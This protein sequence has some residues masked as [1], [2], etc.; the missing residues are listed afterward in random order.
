MD[1][2]CSRL[3]TALCAML[4]D[5]RQSVA[6]DTCLEKLL[7]WVRTVTEA[8]EMADR[9]LSTPREEA[10]AFSGSGSPSW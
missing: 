4:V 8:G 6:D 5:S 7:D 9:L 2:E 10:P 3:L 1:P